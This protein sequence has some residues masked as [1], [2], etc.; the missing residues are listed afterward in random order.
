MLCLHKRK[1]IQIISYLRSSGTAS[2]SWLGLG[3]ME[4]MMGIS[5]SRASGCNAGAPHG[6]LV[7]NRFFRCR[8]DEP[9]FEEG[10]RHSLSKAYTDIPKTH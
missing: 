4:S 3:L 7:R 10:V 6:M 8:D 9:G 2:G 1:I 5:T